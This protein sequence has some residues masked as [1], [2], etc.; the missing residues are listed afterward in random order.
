METLRTADTKFQEP[1]PLTLESCEALVSDLRSSITHITKRMQQ[2]EITQDTS[3]W[4]ANE[5]RI[6]NGSKQYLSPKMVAYSRALESYVEDEDSEELSLLAEVL[7]D[8]G[9][10]ITHQEK[11]ESDPK[12]KEEIIKFN[13]KLRDLI[14]QIADVVPRQ[15]LE[16][17]LSIFMQQ[18]SREAKKIVAGM[19]AEVAVYRAALAEF[20]LANVK[21]SD[22]EQDLSGVD[23]LVRVDGLWRKIDVKTGGNQGG[24]MGRLHEVDVDQTMVDGFDIRPEFMQS[25]I[26]QIKDS[27]R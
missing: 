3:Q 17:W 16:S 6:I 22:E 10:Y 15:Q 24:G 9:V 2:A 19:G 20:G 27:S 21:L 18:N 14:V 11:V 4:R 5:I 8:A 7:L 26:N 23:L 1:T 13:H 25:I 12:Y